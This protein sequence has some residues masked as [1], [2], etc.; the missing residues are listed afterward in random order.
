[1]STAR[2]LSRATALVV[3]LTLFVTWPQGLVPASQLANHHD[4]LFSIWRLGWI[5]HGLV[6]SPLHLFDA[7]IFHP[8][9]TTLAYSDATMLEGLIAAPLFW[10]G[11]PP[12]L[13]YNL[14]L[15]AGFAGS[16]VAMFV[17][18]RHV[19]GAE[20][21]ALLSAAV[22]TLLPYRIEHFMHLEL[23]WA[24][25]IPLTLWA[26]HRTVESGELRWGAIAGVCFWLQVLACV[27]YGVFLGLTLV[28]FVPALVLATARTRTRAVVLPL[29]AAGVVAVVLTAPFAWPYRAAANELGGR[30]AEEI[31]RYSATFHSYFATTTWNR[32]W[33]WTADRWG[34]PELRLFPG[35]VA[36][37]LAALAVVR[38]PSRVTL[39]YVLLAVTAVELSFGFNGTI[40]RALVD[41]VE[42]L[43][44]FRATARF[45][46]IASC[47][48]ALLAGVGAHAW[49]Q[50][51]P[52]TRAASALM[53]MLL[54][55][56]MADSANRAMRLMPAESPQTPDVYKILESAAPGALLELPLPNLDRLPG[57]EPEYQAWSLWHF[58]P[59]VNGYSGYYPRD[60]ITTVLRM[61]VFPGEGTLDR[62]RA[63]DVRFIIVH[64]AFYDQERY[65]QLMLRMAT[66]PE[67][68]PWGAYK[69][70]VGTADIFE[71]LPVD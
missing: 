28:V 23:Q 32:V 52:A 65:T 5:A 46:V 14:M 71:L 43:R 21:P 22:F 3:G 38:R 12:A 60:Y 29:L 51:W 66:R 30:T 40:Y 63:H 36:L 16:G 35:A 62:L 25:F 26:L 59:L 48:V 37:A 47:A 58:R 18:A 64:R 50:A 17:L 8:A 55:L 20:G 57:W 70:P 39:V 1:M 24:M 56:I 69:D 49:R 67:L 4:A 45:A 10:A 27:Y 42:A 34:G 19:I 13:T 31:A 2:S 9:K 41:H 33:G 44:G 11:L 6:T 54:A 7:N 61:N 53:P 15:L 68:K